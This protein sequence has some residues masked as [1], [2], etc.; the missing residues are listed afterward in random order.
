[1]PV[2][3]WWIPKLGKLFKVIGVARI[4]TDNQNELSLKDQEAYYREWLDKE[5]GPGNYELTVIAYRGSGQIVDSKEFLKLC[6]LIDSGDYDL[7]VAEDLSRISRRFLLLAILENAEATRTRLVGIGD[8]FDSSQ[9]GWEVSA[10]FAT[11]KNKMFCKDTARRIRRT[12]RNRFMSGG[13]VMCLQYG[14]DKPHPKATDEEVTKTSG[15]DEVY[16]QWI[17][18]LEHGASYSEVARWLEANSVP[19]GPYC[20]LEKW[21]GAMVKRC[22]YNPIICGSRQRNRKIVDR[23]KSG[24]PRTIDAPPEELLTRDVPHLA[25]ITVERWQR[26][27]RKLDERNKKY[28][29]SKERRN[30][31]RANVSRKK[32]RWPGQHLRCG[33]CGRMYLH[34]GHGRP[35]RMMCSGSRDYVCFNAMTVNAPQVVE[36]LGSDIRELVRNLPSFNDKWIAEYELQRSQ[37]KASQSSQAELLGKKLKQKNIELNNL[38][39]GLAKLGSSDRVLE[40]IKR[41]EEEVGLLQGDLYELDKEN[42]HQVELPSLEEISSVADECFNDLAI[43]SE[44]FGRLMKSV[45]TEFF[46][47]PY[48]LADG[49]HVQPKLVYRASLAP[50]VNHPELELLQ[51]DRVVDLCKVPRRVLY[52]HEVVQMKEAG[53]KHADIGEKL[54][55]SKTEVGHAM[56]LYRAM[57]KLN[58]R[59]PWVPIV[60]PQQVEDYF[61]RVRN[62]HFKFEPL[63]GFESSRHPKLD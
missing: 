28:R 46:V 25:F 34:G 33:V 47:L 1:M 32:T 31:P 53:E 52:L 4:S 13:I 27:I 5:Y 48:R 15:S 43:E 23:K 49:G 30:D 50:L 10:M 12:L 38:V 29:R 7:V 17:S 21:T 14:Y 18:D 24:R 42:D 22:T 2:R 37:R 54:T 20:R 44:E 62:S 51:F 40:Q 6:E 55:I 19:T 3:N 35:D 8:S 9:D 16:E 39:A 11:L 58:V 61:K 59:D 63:E 36:A 60:E 56:R 41:C 45:V 26:L 57:Q